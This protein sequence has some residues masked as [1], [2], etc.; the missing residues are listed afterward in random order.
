[1]NTEQAKKPLPRRKKQ[2]GFTLIEL[3]IVVAIILIIA[4]IAIP[5]YLN[6]RAAA[7]ESA[8]GGSVRSVNTALASYQSKWD[9]FPPDLK[10][11]GGDC[12]ATPASATASCNMDD[13]TA[14]AMDAGT[15]VNGY[16]YTYAQV[17]SG[18]GFTLHADPAPGNRA[19]K[20]FFASET[21]TTHYN[22]TAPATATDP[23]VGQ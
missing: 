14:K 20:H 5:N 12:S 19:T 7:S 6:S 23:A 16:L 17:G 8:A 18:T 9:V 2:K 10:S 15:K 1:M 21:L 4:A 22:N 13:G 3:L 11:L